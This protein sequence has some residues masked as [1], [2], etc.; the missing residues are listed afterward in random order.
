MYIHI[1]TAK[2]YIYIIYTYT[3]VYIYTYTNIQIY[4]NAYIFGK[5]ILP[6]KMYTKANYRAQN[7]I[8]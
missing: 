6:V 2:F 5:M 4:T 3:F 7:D 1:F 8:A